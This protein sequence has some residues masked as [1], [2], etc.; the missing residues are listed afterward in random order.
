MMVVDDSIVVRRLVPQH[1]QDHPRIHIAR[2]AKDGLDALAKLSLGGVDVV[3]LD[4]EMPKLNG[5][6]TLAQIHA[7]YPEIKVIMFSAINRAQ[8]GLTLDALSA[9]ASD[10]ITKPSALGGADA[11]EVWV[12]LEAR[13]DALCP[14][15]PEPAPTPRPLLR[16]QV[17]P[18]PAPRRLS[19]SPTPTPRARPRPTPRAAE[20]PAERPV[21]RA[22]E[23]P[24]ERA[25]SPAIPAAHKS[26]AAK[27]RVSPDVLVIGSSTGGPK[28]LND[29]LERF[30][31]P[32]KVPTLIVQHMPPVFTQ[33]LAERLG[34]KTGLIIREAVDG[35]PV[36]AGEILI[37]PGGYHM[38]IKRQGGGVRV[39]LDQG[40]EVNFVRPAVDVLLD[41]VAD[42]YGG[43]SRVAILTGMGRDGCDGCVNLSRL[44][45]VIFAQDQASS[46]VWGMPGAVARAGVADEILPLSQIGARIIQ[47]L[48]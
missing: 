38:R 11:R 37:A 46:V 12:T 41:A 23:R 29:V 16:P 20:R 33:C 27:L 4:V 25:T 9:G 48:T 10:Y 13:I 19:A 35:E 34:R 18:T 43:K 7:R 6:E 36:N 32:L 17:T 30:D 31:R 45:A 3:L 24:V 28:A 21:E 1:F 44:G 26:A 15:E 39:V 5:V 40:P 8:A 47:G 22:A 14:V 2:V 42:V